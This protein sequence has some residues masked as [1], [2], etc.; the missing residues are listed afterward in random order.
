M[1][2]KLLVL[3]SEEQRLLEVEGVT[4]PTD[5]PL[6]KVLKLFTCSS[7]MES[8][9]SYPGGGRGALTYET[10]RDAHRLA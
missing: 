1:Q 5:M 6:T 7:H 2:A 9:G 10:E 4:L 3:S 8:W